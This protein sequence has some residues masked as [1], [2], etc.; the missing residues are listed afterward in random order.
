MTDVVVTGLG[1]VSPLGYG[2]RELYES[3]CAG[4]GLAPGNVAHAPDVADRLSVKEGRRLD[5]FAKF[6]LIAAIEAVD[7]AGI[8]LAEEQPDRVGAVVGTGVGG[9]ETLSQGIETLREKGDRL[10]PA[11]TVPMLMSNA[12]VSALTLRWGLMGPGFSVSTA[13][14][15]GNHSLGQAKRMIEFGEADV[16]LAGGAEAAIH[17]LATAAFTA[18]G[19][20]TKQGI[21]CPFD[22]RR[23]GFVMSE[24]AAVLV[25]ESAEHA[26][27]RGARVYCELA[28]YG[29]S[30][31]AHHLV[32]PDPEGRGAKLAIG[33]ALA[34]AGVET[35]DYVNAHG[36]ST[37]FNDLAETR[38]V[39]ELLG[40][41]V[42]ISSTKSALGHSLA[43][44]GALE[45]VICS[46]SLTEQKVHPTL[47]LE[48]P[49]PECDLDYVREGAR[50]LRLD[51]VLSNSFGFGGH[52][53]C[54]VF[55]K[56]SAG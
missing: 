4:L 36:T 54:L 29:A 13:C 3:V 17:P 19:A 41:D 6:A 39:K 15:T 44:A 26:A 5:R 25:L 1:A 18:M 27:A 45:A 20:M 40:A 50:D 53:A 35:V 22:A 56:A 12:A 46:L 21:S 8:D 31:D 28:G 32:Q 2:A 33:K 34:D 51:T 14:A 48:E 24:G 47:N 30:H 49:D 9:I 7:D 42:P 52:N 11:T 55:K 16:V 23:D 43:A 37:P 10:V 38:A